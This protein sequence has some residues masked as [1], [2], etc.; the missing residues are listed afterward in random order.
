LRRVTKAEGDVTKREGQLRRARDD[1]AHLERRITQLQHEI[2]GLADA[3]HKADHLVAAGET[4]L[5]HAKHVLA[6]SRRDLKG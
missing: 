1:A 3:K 5:A 4:A 2:D 6:E